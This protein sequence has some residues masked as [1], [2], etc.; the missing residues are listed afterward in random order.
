MKKNN[1]G[2]T[3]VELI[4]V[5]AIIGVL[6]AILIPSL[7]GYVADSKLET[8]NSNAKGIYTAVSRIA[9]KQEAKGVSIGSGRMWKQSSSGA[10]SYAASINTSAVSFTTIDA[11]LGSGSSWVYAIWMNNG[12][13][14]AVLA[15]KTSTDLYVGSYPT[16]ADAKSA[17]ALSSI[18]TRG[19]FSKTSKANTYLA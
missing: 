15:A 10:G 3:L 7:M 9:A 17:N 6:A 5:I 8:A 1:K 2:F 13:P 19:D 18:N 14:D 11:E 16:P 4:V 12:L